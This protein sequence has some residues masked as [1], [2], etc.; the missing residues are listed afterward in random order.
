MQPVHFGAGRELAAA[1]HEG[2]G[3]VLHDTKLSG[4][5][6]GPH[7]PPQLRAVRQMHQDLR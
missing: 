1:R 6:R 3:E 5:G 2:D 7:H 4:Q